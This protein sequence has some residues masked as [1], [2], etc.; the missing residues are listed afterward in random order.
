MSPAT[1]AVMLSGTGR[2]LVNLCEKIDA[3]A[4]PARVSLVIASRPCPGA[5][6]A[7]ERGIP[8][9]VMPGPI[10]ADD[11][12]RTLRESGADFVAL[13][14]YL[15]MVNIP[16][17]YRWRVVNIHP[18]LLPSFGGPGMHGLRVHEAVLAAGCKVSGCTA[19]LC[20]ERYDT[21][22]ILVQRACEVQE[23]DTPQTLAARVFDLECEAYPAAIRLLIEG[24]VRVEGNRARILHGDRPATR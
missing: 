1:L 13:A 22:P 6:R 20:D 12:E 5:E 24:R 17:S 3:G 18:A 14:G 16:A 2:T 15:R 23:D 8:V 19:H 7:R 11:L 21:G 10:R 9:R 4:L